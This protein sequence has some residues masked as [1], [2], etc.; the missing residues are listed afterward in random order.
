MQGIRHFITLLTTASQW[1]LS[2]SRSIQCISSHTF[3]IHFN[4]ILPL[5]LG[6]SCSRYVLPGIFMQ[7]SYFFCVLYVLKLECNHIT[8]LDRTLGL[9]NVEASRMSR[10]RH[11][12]V[13]RLS[14]LR[15]DRLYP[16]EISLT[17]IPVRGQ[18]DPTAVVQPEGSSRWSHM[19]RNS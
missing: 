19:E 17:L 9:Q 16:Q 18:V 15:S 11:M 8:H 2:C 5:R 6:P 4:I 13:V 3:K 10:F 7:L 12:K 1:S 14:A